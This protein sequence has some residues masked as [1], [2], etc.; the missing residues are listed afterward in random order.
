MY[1]P[2]LFFLFLG[3][4][5]NCKAQTNVEYVIYGTYAGE[6]LG[7]CAHIFKFSN[8]TLLSDTSNDFLEYHFGRIK[9]YVFKGIPLNRNRYLKA[10]KIMDSIP[11]FL[12]T[13]ETE[14]FGCPDCR[15][16]G[17]IY[18][19]IKTKDALKTFTIDTDIS[20]V[21]KELWNY[22]SLLR[23]SSY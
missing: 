19:Q 12:F 21:P 10:K 16:Q 4:Q 7:H 1:V 6:C 17:G 2:I 18:L 14:R 8:D 5:Y 22:V 3:V 15:D 11:P 20:I 9:N 13:T 23:Q